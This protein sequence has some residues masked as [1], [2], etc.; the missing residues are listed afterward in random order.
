[1][2]WPRRAHCS[3]PAGSTRSP[4]RR[5]RTQ[6]GRSTSAGSAQNPMH[7]GNVSTPV[8]SAGRKGTGRK[9]AG[10]NTLTW[11][12]VLL[13]PKLHLLFPPRTRESPPPAPQQREGV[14]GTGGGHL[15][16]DLIVAA[17]MRGVQVSQSPQPRLAGRDTEVIGYSS[18]ILQARQRV[19]QLA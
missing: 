11:P 4:R 10:T 18:T 16:G 13:L 2:T 6:R 9:L 5:R 12:P 8:N 17:A 14:G 15:E 3:R 7:A 1:M 19:A